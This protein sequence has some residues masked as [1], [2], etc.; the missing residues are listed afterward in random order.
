MSFNSM[1]KQLNTI[2][3]YDLV[4]K[5]VLFEPSSNKYFDNCVYVKSIN[6]IG[7]QNHIHYI[8]VDKNKYY[9]NLIGSCR[10]IVL[11]YHDDI[12]SE[13]KT[14]YKELYYN[15]SSFS[16]KYKQLQ[17]DYN[18]LLQKFMTS[19]QSHQH[20]DIQK[21]EDLQY[22]YDELTKLYESNKKEL[23]QTT[24]KLH[25]SQANLHD[26]QDDFD[27]LM[28]DSMV[29]EEQLKND[30]DCIQSEIKNTLNELSIVSNDL[31]NSKKQYQQLQKDFDEQRETYVEDRKILQDKINDYKQ[32]IK[33]YEDDTEFM[34]QKL[35]DE[36]LVEIKNEVKSTLVENNKSLATEF[37][38]DFDTKYNEKLKKETIERLEDENIEMVR[39]GIWISMVNEM[40]QNYDEEAKEVAKDQIETD[41]RLSIYKKIKDEQTPII[42]QEL[43][44]KIYN[45]LTEGL[46]DDYGEELNLNHPIV[47]EIIQIHKN[48][49]QNELKDIVIDELMS[50]LEQEVKAQ[51][52]TD[53][54]YIV[55][56]ELRNDLSDEIRTELTDKFEKENIKKLKDKC[57]KQLI[58]KFDTNK[59]DE[60]DE[61]DEYEVVSI[62]EKCL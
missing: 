24:K 55:K 15:Y 1:A 52:Y 5:Y 34:S 38:N 18:I 22:K 61:Y 4:N 8:D 50:S 49:N 30:N 53:L 6:R 13:F 26:L 23:E 36:L 19:F 33:T 62:D 43:R 2:N 20:T 44:T 12:E 60:A 17:Q 46:Y 41:L 40:K 45:D 10:C 47:K 42:T 16:N 51:L 27:G 25:N 7:G 39:N 28:K 3:P 14:K 35:Y 58:K 54:Y 56:V 9:V 31:K 48:I 32:H 37:M 29:T 21:I 59:H 57:L 11:N